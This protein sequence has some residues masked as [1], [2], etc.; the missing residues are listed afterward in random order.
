MF[1]NDT[2]ARSLHQKSKTFYSLL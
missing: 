1:P 2:L